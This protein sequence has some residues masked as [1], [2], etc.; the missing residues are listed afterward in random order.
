M[1]REKYFSNDRNWYDDLCG[2]V[3][4]IDFLMKYVCQSLNLSQ[5]NLVA[6]HGFF[7][8]SVSFFFKP[9]THNQRRIV[10]CSVDR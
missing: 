6:K 4:D 5:F 1:I 10:K 3:S 7:C 8:V 2:E 9:R